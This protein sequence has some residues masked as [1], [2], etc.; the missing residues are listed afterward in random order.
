MGMRVHP[1]SI[2]K[3]KEKLKS[4]TGRSNDMSMEMQAIKVKQLVI[5]WVEYFKLADMKDVL[6]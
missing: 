2:K 5:G 6:R 4:I 1:S 3:L